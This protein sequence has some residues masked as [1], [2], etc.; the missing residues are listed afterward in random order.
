MLACVDPADP[1]QGPRTARSG[2][3]RMCALTRE[4]RPVDELIRFVVAP[5][6]AVVPD[7][8]RKLPGRGLW[9]TASQAAVAE[10]GKRGV[11]SRGFK[12]TVAAAPTLAEDTGRWLTRG[13]VEA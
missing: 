4:V 9:I 10:A 12:R 1:D 11:F 2:T 5:D 8:K 13:A 6:G 7:L 3:A